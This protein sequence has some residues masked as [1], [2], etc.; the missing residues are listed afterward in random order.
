MANTDSATQAISSAA[1][2]AK[3]SPAQ[4]TA[5][6]PAR[7]WVNPALIGSI[8]LLVIVVGILLFRQRTQ[9]RVAA[10]SSLITRSLDRGR[11]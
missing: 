7:A 10:Q 11:K 5:V 3:P 1:S 8:A 4:G 2:N 6:V 9:Q